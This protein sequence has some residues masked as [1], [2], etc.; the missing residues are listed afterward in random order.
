MRGLTKTAEITQFTEQ[1]I[2][3][4]CEN[5]EEFLASGSIMPH[6]RLLRGAVKII[7]QLQEERQVLHCELSEYEGT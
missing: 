1:E 7:R 2:T 3:D 6:R 4:S 5:M